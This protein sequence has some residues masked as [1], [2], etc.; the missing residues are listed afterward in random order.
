[1]K[2]LKEGVGS[3]VEGTH[4]SFEDLKKKVEDATRKLK[5]G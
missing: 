3:G 4:R 5:A 1:M 2:K